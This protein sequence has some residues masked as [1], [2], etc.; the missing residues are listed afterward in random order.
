MHIKTSVKLKPELYSELR[1][2]H[3]QNIR[4]LAE[5][6]LQRQVMK[7]QREVAK[8]EKRSQSVE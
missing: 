2:Q 6:E 5:C 4:I 7:L 1:Q 3:E 8:R